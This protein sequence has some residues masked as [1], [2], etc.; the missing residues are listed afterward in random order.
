M[1]KIINGKKYDTDT[2]KEVGSDSNGG[3]RLDFWEETLYQKR[4]GEFFLF[5]EGGPASRYSK[6]CGNN[7]WSGGEQIIPLSWDAAKEWAEEHMD[8]DA[9]ESVFGEVTEDDSKK[10][11]P[12]TLSV[13]LLERVKRLAS[14]KGI[15]AS[16]VIECALEIY[17]SNNEI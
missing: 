12:A 14:Q 9:Y 2:A 16:S 10:V 6:S 15:S 1:K 7:N 8:A 4:T 3:S 5:G 17:L 11:F 13:S